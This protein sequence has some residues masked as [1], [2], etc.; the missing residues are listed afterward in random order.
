LP[1]RG[2]AVRPDRI[3]GQ[4]I[5]SG[6]RDFK[7]PRKVVEKF[8]K[9]WLL[10]IL[11]HLLTDKAVEA[12]SR[13]KS[14]KTYM[15]DNETVTLKTM[16]DDL[17]AD[18]KLD[19]DPAEFQQAYPRFLQ[20]VS[21]FFPREWPRWALHHQRLGLTKGAFGKKFPLYL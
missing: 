9:G 19:M 15:V 16:S 2:K 14:R 21:K 11:L 6:K 1:K 13:G 10:H 18:G 20:C 7:I 17:N 5:Q 8:S 12:A 3:I 4:V